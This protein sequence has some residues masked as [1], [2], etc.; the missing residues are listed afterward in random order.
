[1]P[2]HLFELL[3]DITDLHTQ[4]ASA[5]HSSRASQFPLMLHFAETFRP[6]VHRLEAHQAY[7]V[8]LEQVTKELDNIILDLESNYGQFIRS[9]SSAPECGSMGLTSFLLKPMQRLTKYP[10]FFK[11]SDVITSTCVY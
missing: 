7:L 8:H 2:T 10:L 11:V 4:I 3:D 5:L 9:Q 1:M 6:F